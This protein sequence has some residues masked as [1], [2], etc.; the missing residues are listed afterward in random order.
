MKS[1][2]HAISNSLGT[3]VPEA[4]IENFQANFKGKLIFRDDKDY[5]TSRLVWNKMIDKYPSVIAQCTGVA[6]IISAVNFARD[7]NMSV[8]VRG[9]GHNVAGNAVGDSV[10]TIDLSNMRSVRVD[11]IRKTANVQGGATWLDVDHETQAF[12]LAC[13]G[14]VVSETGVA[15]L[16]LG[17]GLSWMRRKV[18]MSIDNLIGADV[19]LANGNFVHASEKENADLFWAVRGGGGN[20]GIVSNF[21]FKLTDLGPTV[22]FTA[23]MYPRKEAEKVLSYWVNYTKNAPDNI[24][25]DCILWAV[26]EHPNFPEELHNHKVIVVAGMYA[27]KAEEGE[28]KMQPLREIATPLLDMSNV[29]PYKMVQQ[30]FDP[31]LEKQKLNSYWKCIYL[32]ELTDQLQ[33]RVIKRA[34]EVQNPQSLISIRNLQGAISRV[35]SDETAFGDRNARFLL[36]IDT[37]WLNDAD[38]ERNMNW[39]RD[40][41]NEM[42]GFSQGKV[43]FNFN[44]D[45]SS[46]S[47]ILKVSFGNNFQKLSAIKAKYDPNNF[48]NLNANIKPVK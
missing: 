9:G 26:P 44:S 20:F 35:G 14:G 2:L 48:F 24:T 4:A 10:L 25:S 19:V 41:F 37:M 27:G 6:D 30:M 21:E 33:I 32:D 3:E 22:F 39:T 5:D 11:P 43:Y 7:N 28:K 23:C 45:M 1:T 38:N 36:S 34:A 18:G 40:F 12:G 29:Y 16:T 13:P 46:P 31:F 15:G 47:D 17:G 8:S 42:Q